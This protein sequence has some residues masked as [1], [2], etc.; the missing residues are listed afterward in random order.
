MDPLT[1]A[2][3]VAADL[4]LD[5]RDAVV[6]RETRSAVVDLAPAPVVARVW[7]AGQRDLDV[8]RRELAVTAYLAHAGAPVAAPWTQPGPYE[9]GGPRGHPVAAR[10]PR[11]RPAARRRRGRPGAA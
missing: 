9:R 1:A 7:P 6:L 3:E 5:A 8:V 4:G 10:R 11:P 2:R